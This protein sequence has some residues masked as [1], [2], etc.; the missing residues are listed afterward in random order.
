M[1]KFEEYKDE[2]IVFKYFESMRTGI[3]RKSNSYYLNDI[4]IDII[5][6]Y[7]PK[8]LYTGLLLNMQ[9]AKNSKSATVEKFNNIVFGNNRG[10]GISV[11]GYN[12]QGEIIG[13][14]Y[15]YVFDY[16]EK[17]LHVIV[18]SIKSGKDFDISEYED[19]LSS[20]QLLC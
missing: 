5:F 11:L 10:S 2:N 8:E 9:D 13:K 18:D 4:I 12:K 15:E 14:R 16:G 1:S 7:G 6:N 19:I 3:N 20:I 17:S